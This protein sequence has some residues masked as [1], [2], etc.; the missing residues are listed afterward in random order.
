MALAERT[1]DEEMRAR[2]LRNELGGAY[3]LAR[4]TQLALEQYR[5]AHEA[6]LH[7]IVRDPTFRL[8]VLYNLGTTYWMLNQSTDAI[9]YSARRWS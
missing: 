3:L 2:L 9:G 4:K 1:G 5:L 8:N 7:G 6:V